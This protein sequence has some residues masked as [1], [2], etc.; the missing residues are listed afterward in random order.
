MYTGDGASAAA[1]REAEERPTE[2]LRVYAALKHAILAGT[3][4]PGESLQETRLAADYG[5]SRTPIREALLRLESD[6]LLTITPRRG[7]FVQQPTL[8]DFLDV[9]ELRLLLEPAAA[10]TA[11]TMIA[12]DVVA[13][14]QR[15]LA[16]ITADRPTESD[17]AAL[18]QLDLRL[19]LSISEAIP[20]LRM[21][22]IIGSLND[23]MQIVRHQDM[24]R[25]HQELHASIGEVLAALA[26]RD[27]DTTE[28]AMRR[29]IAAFSGALRSLV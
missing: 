14:L 20:N 29:H 12:S 22:K 27:P 17:Y 16:A 25:R 19:H 24:R 13:D 2:T 5:A 23:M 3:Y 10:R 26:L 18:E 4:R 9:N 21:A 8:R 1:S 6:G 7:A 15:A 11:T 28:R